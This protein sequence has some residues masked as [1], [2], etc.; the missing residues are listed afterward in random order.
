VT[1]MSL[2]V[3]LPV[4][5]DRKRT[6]DTVRVLVDDKLTDMFRSLVN[7]ID[8]N[9]CSYVENFIQCL[10]DMKCSCLLNSRLGRFADFERLSSLL[11]LV[12]CSSLFDP[13]FI[14]VENEIRIRD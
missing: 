10:T 7:P 5:R 9:R 11:L 14:S 12:M 2:F 13:M 3:V 4:A 8:K 6:D 1:T